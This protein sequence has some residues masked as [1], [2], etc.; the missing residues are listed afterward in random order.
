MNGNFDVVPCGKLATADELLRRANLILRIETSALIECH[1]KLAPTSP[2]LSPIPGTVNSDI[3]ADAEAQLELIRDIEAH[4]EGDPWE[5]P[6]G[7]FDDI[8]HRRNG[9]EGGLS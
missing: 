9:W 4:L 2:V 1:S 8:L 6:V 7:W 5:G 3:I